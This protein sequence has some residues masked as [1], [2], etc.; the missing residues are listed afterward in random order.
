MKGL[1]DRDI[2]EVIA[3]IDLLAG[4]TAPPAHVR[5]TDEEVKKSLRTVALWIWNANRNLQELAD[6]TE[7]ISEL[8][9]MHNVVSSKPVLLKDVTDK[10]HDEYERALER[11]RA[12]QADDKVKR[13]L[14]SLRTLVES[15]KQLIP[16]QK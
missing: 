14:A 11:F 12:L 9:S 4:G 13:D 7:Q 2:A 16:K 1:F 3:K 6:L 10:L 5:K 8:E 15:I